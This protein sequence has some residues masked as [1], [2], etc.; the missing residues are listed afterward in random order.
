MVDTR[1]DFV[2]TI[3][4]KKGDFHFGNI[5]KSR[6]VGSCMVFRWKFHVSSTRVSDNGT[7][8]CDLNMDVG[9]GII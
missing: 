8:V 1:K 2:S 6:S 9:I 5:G 7:M 4:S 3:S